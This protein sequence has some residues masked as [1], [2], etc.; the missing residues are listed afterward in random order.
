MCTLFTAKGSDQCFRAIRDQNNFADIRNECER[1]WGHYK[2]LAPENFADQFSRDF[3]ARFWEMHLGVLL[4]AYY[5]GLEVNKP[6]PDF[7]IP[8]RDSW[9]F[10]EA[11][12]ASRGNTV[13]AVPDISSRS[14]DDDTVPFN[15]CV[16]RITSSLAEKSKA[17]QAKCFAKRGAYIVAVNLPFPEAWLCGTP[18]LSAQ[19]TLGLGGEVFALSPSSEDGDLN[20]ATAVKSFISRIPSIQKRETK[21]DVPT[22]AF[23]SPEYKHVSAL[24]VAS[25]NPFSSAYDHP[26]M[27]MLHNP[28][29]TNPL[30]RGWL[31]VGNEYWV[32]DDKLERRSHGA[33][34]RPGPSSANL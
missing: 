18:P 29:A 7:H 10:V 25:V 33:A 5:P 32:E 14:D 23:L 31:K 24:L 34:R 11:T 17:N 15:E 19:A 21:G 16:L 3:R 1:L 12:S 8:Y 30:P 20:Y 4:R 9:I 26:S 2:E 28:R 13:D 6:G 22:T 27:E